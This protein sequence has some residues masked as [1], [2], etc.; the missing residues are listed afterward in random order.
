MRRYELRSTLMTS[1]R[2]IENWGHLIGDVPARRGH[3]RQPAPKRRN[4]PLQRPQLPSAQRSLNRKGTHQLMPKP[5]PPSQPDSGIIPLHSG[6]AGTY[7]ESGWQTAAFRRAK[8]IF[9]SEENETR[10][11]RLTRPELTANKKPLGWCILIRPQVV[12]FN[13][14]VTYN[15]RSGRFHLLNNPRKTPSGSSGVCA[16]ASHQIL[17]GAPP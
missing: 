13:R 15:R 8:D 10:E 2:P 5:P 1:N 11:G 3:P 4:H 12:H 16:C 14:P 6:P 9:L 7:T 17:D